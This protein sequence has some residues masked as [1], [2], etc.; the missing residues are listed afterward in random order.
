[1][2]TILITGA[3]SGIAHHVINKLLKQDYHIYVAVH[4]LEELKQIQKKYQEEIHVT[5]LKIDL[6]NPKDWKQLENISLDVYIA[7]A[8]IG[9]G[10]TI[11]NMDI[12]RI[13]ENYE[14]NVFRNLEL[15]Q[16]ILKKMQKQGHGKIIIMSSL[17]GIL[18]IPFL[19]S[20]CSTKASLIKWVECLRLE[21]LELNSKIQLSLV[22]PGIYLTG[23]NRVMLENK[24]P[25]LEQENF[26]QNYLDWLH[27]QDA[28]YLKLGKK[29]VSIIVQK[30]CQAINSD[31][32]KFIYRAPLSQV[33]IAK[34][35][36]ILFS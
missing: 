19:G 7:N 36:Q 32:P 2:Q 30:I 9:M 13:R 17:A 12:E 22:E 23:F 20:Y 16:F 8:A 3:R 25:E 6:K 28:I 11:L 5:C 14:V 35:Y 4:T 31:H 10:G 26:F 1:M 21:L 33:I 15:L 34:I 24:Y 29:D 27:M 18:P